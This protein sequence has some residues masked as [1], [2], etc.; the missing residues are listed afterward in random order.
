MNKHLE[1]RE[2]IATF[3]AL[4]GNSPAHLTKLFNSC[5]NETHNLRSNFDQLLL[6]KPNSNFVKK[7]FLTERQNSGKTFP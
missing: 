4:T 5:S 3:K 6:A 1:I 7:T 2:H